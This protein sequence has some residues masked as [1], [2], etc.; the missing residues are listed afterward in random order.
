[1]VAGSRSVLGSFLHANNSTNM[2]AVQRIAYILSRPGAETV[3][4]SW[5]QAQLDTFGQ[6]SMPD[7]NSQ[8][9]YRCAV[10]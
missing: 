10:L 7:S 5:K 3:L 8:N 2:Q 6:F 4:T 1:M 9:M